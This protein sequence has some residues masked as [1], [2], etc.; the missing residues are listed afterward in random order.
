MNR[1]SQL[2]RPPIRRASLD[3]DASLETVSRPIHLLKIDAPRALPS[4][5]R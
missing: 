3:D 5:T 4:Q 2:P 1:V